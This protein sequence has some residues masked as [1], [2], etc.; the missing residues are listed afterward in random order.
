MCLV[1]LGSA[2]GPAWAQQNR[3]RSGRAGSGGNQQSGGGT[4]TP[5]GGGWQN[6]GGGWQNQG[7]QG[8]GG[9]WQNQW[10]RQ[11]NPGWQQGHQPELQK[12]YSNLPIH[13]TLPPDMTGHVAYTLNG[14]QYKI[15]PGQTQHFREDRDWVIQFDR[16]PEYGSGMYSLTGGYYSFKRS[17]RG[18]EL[19]RQAGG[20]PAEGE[21]SSG[22]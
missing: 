3:G 12:V 22:F 9:G 6:G 19:Y 2:S 1:V 7:Q 14:Y 13:I 20:A 11:P 15:Q 5:P 17:D 8:G 18:W 21:F 4:F 16:G 10:Q